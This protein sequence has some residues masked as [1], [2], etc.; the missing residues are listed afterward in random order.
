MFIYGHLRCYFVLFS[1]NSPVDVVL[2]FL[3]I[4]IWSTGS[5]KHQIYNNTLNYHNRY[6]MFSGGRNIGRLHNLE[7]FSREFMSC[8]Q[9]YESE[10]TVKAAP[11]PPSELR[12]PLTI[13]PVF[14]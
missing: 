9:N 3:I 4:M 14:N 8:Y 2:A 6:F 13:G 5:N 7:L 12:R 11:V 10:E 1:F